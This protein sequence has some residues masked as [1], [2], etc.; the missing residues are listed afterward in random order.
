MRNGRRGA[1]AS[2]RTKA[3]AP[4]P[5]TKAAELVAFVEQLQAMGVTE[6]EIARLV[7]QRTER[8]D[9]GRGGVGV[10]ADRAGAGA[11]PAP[12]DGDGDSR[13][14]GRSDV[15][16]GAGAGG[17]GSRTG[18]GGSGKRPLDPHE[19]DG[20]DPEKDRTLYTRTIPVNAENRWRWAI[21]HYEGYDP[22][23]VVQREFLG[24]DGKWKRAF[25]DTLRN[26]PITFGM[27]V[28]KFWTE[29]EKAMGGG[30]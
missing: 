11:A 16:E 13:G 23:L 5:P 17:G 26:V 15:A 9:S 25:Q 1:K 3:K 19:A 29:A 24:R 6:P 18:G 8:R 14:A 28:A 12:G 4:A 30:A 21:R 22:R 7:A 2:G 10:L 20:Y 27:D